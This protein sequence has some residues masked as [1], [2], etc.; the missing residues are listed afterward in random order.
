[1]GIFAESL[2]EILLEFLPDKG[3]DDGVEAAVHEG[4]C[5]GQLQGEVKPLAI[6]AVIDDMQAPQRVQQEHD[7]DGGPEQEEHNDDDK[8]QFHCFVLVLSMAPL[9]VSQDV[10]VAKNE[11]AHREQPPQDV[12]FR[13]TEDLPAITA[14][15][16][17][18][19][20]L[21]PVILIHFPEEHKAWH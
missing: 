11:D 1:M 7:I 8:N 19:D 12:N 14:A 10:V 5:L 17:V 20:A 9:Q 21:C 15:R 3:V 4:E 2:T 13:I 18:R 16:V 6:L